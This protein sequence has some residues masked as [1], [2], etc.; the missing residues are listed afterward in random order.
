MK[1]LPAISFCFSRWPQS[2]KESTSPLLENSGPLRKRPQ[3]DVM[4]W[5]AAFYTK[6]A[7][8]F[9]SFGT[10]LEAPEWLPLINARRPLFKA[11]QSSNIVMKAIISTQSSQYLSCMAVFIYVH[12]SLS[13]FELIHITVGIYPVHLR[14]FSLLISACLKLHTLIN[15]AL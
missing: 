10:K 15:Y 13:F 11:T 3:P 8:P 14:H 12:F 5:S 2:L 1:P 7:V 6:G 4:T 9:N